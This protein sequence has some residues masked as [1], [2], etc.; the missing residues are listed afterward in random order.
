MPS[1]WAMVDNSFPT[2]AEEENPRQ[3]VA[4]L[5]DYIFILVEE[6]K[7][8]LENLD[9]ENWNAVA[10]QE[11]QEETTADTNKDVARLAASVAMLQN[12]LSTAT[13][14]LGSRVSAVEADV[15]YLE[16]GLAE[17]AAEVRGLETNLSRLEAA[18]GELDEEVGTIRAD[19]GKLLAVVAPGET[20]CTI[21]TAG[22]RLNL[23]GEVFV[24]GKLLE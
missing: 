20:G 24:N 15:G 16:T 9:A 3:S 4:K 18:V 21:G 23:V 1:K 14:S 2:F 10:L 13:A 17:T 19:L 12:Q 6:L 7:Y 22:Q 8:Q 11:I 5:T